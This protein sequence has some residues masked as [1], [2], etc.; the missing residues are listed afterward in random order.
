MRR[1][2]MTRFS[3]SF[4]LLFALS[5]T[6]HA[7]DW[8]DYAGMFPTFPCH[9]GWVGCVVKGEHVTPEPTRGDARNPTPANQRIDFLTLKP[10]AAFNPFSGLSDY[11]GI[12]AAAKAPPP[13]PPPDPVPE[14]VAAVVPDAAPA[15]VPDAVAVAP[16]PTPQPMVRPDPRPEPAPMVRPDP[17]P[18]PAPMVRPDPK[19]EPAP[20]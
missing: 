9:D 8:S 12:A 17:K 13:P 18:E 7:T 4:A 11:S 20:M 1:V 2:Y 10:T 5:G 15:P 16:T 3:V 6:A 19:P 14:P